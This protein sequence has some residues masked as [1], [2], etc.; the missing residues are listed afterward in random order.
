MVRF[1][2]FCFYCFFVSVPFGVGFIVFTPD[3][4][5]D[6]LNP[7]LSHSL[8]ISDFFW[9]LGILS[10][11]FGFLKGELKDV[12]WM[13]FFK[14]KFF[15]VIAAVI[16]AYL[17]SIIVSVD[18]LNS[19]IYL[20]RI[21]Q[22]FVFAALVFLNIVHLKKV[23]DL[24]IVVV[25]FLALLGVFQFIFQ[26]SVGLHFLGEPIVSVDKLGV[27][28][29]SIF[30]KDFLRIYGTFPHP[31]I[32]AGYLLVAIIGAWRFRK[33]SFMRFLLVL[34]FIAL[35]LTFSRSAWLAL[36]IIIVWNWKLKY[37]WIFSSV[38]FFIFFVLLF[39]LTELA[40]LE[41]M[42]FL[43]IS[44]QMFLAHPLG[45]GVGNFTQSMAQV[46]SQNLDPWQIQPVHNVFLL[47]LNELGLQGFTIVF[48]TLIM[49]RF[50]S[51]ILLLVFVIGLFDHYFLSL[52]SGQ[53]LLAFIFAQTDFFGSR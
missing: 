49:R 40:V 34:C 32:F 29:V 52:Y 26:T 53:F 16:L 51:P 33:E 47:L 50:F 18:P 25:S 4:F 11:I 15:S 44:K 1:A 27:A 41:R 2:R 42:Q 39:D 19:M 9:V 5:V 6:F 31:N 37:K 36:L 48:A 22:F 20:F 28:K 3:A 38:L 30:G 46:S 12:Q 35:V 8:Y 23:Y 24:F 10:M 14:S 17:L 45:V 7:Y 43:E 13:V 21:C